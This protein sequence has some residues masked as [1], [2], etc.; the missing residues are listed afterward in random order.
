MDL[1]RVVRELSAKATG[2]TADSR[3]VRQGYV[4]VCLSDAAKQFVPDAI[5]AGAGF[6][7]IGDTDG[8]DNAGSSQFIVC[9]AR[10]DLYH[11]L[12][13]RFYQG[14]QPRFVAAVTG[15]NGKTSVAD[16]CRQIWSLTGQKGASIGTLGKIVGNGVPT[17]LCHRASLT[18]PDPAALH[19]TLRELHD[20]RVEYLCMEA[21]SHGIAQKR[22][23]SVVIQA[24][25]FTNFSQDHLGYHGS[26]EVYWATKRKLFSEVL[27]HEGCAVLNADSGKYAELKRLAKYRKVITYGINKGDV[28][29][30][31]LES[32]KFGHN[33]AVKIQSRIVY[34]GPFHVLGKFQISNLLCALALVVAS[35]S[36]HDNI[37][38]NRLVTPK[39]RMERV[40][41][42]AIVDY[43]HTPEAL[44]QA[45]TSLRWHGF[46]KKI[47]LVFG[48]GGERD[49]EK[50]KTMAMIADKYAH[51]VI[52]TD[53][54]PR[55][56]DPAAIRGEIL[57][58]CKRAIEVPDRREAIHHAISLAVRGDYMLLIVGKGHE[59]TQQIGG[60]AVEFNDA[61]V[62]KS[63]LDTVQ[64]A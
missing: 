35:A 7:V 43:A 31:H 52:I 64:Y 33:I 2:V 44:R 12:A 22:V 62:A 53:D 17:T 11:R 32:N 47:A 58:H 21:S 41:D 57:S 61:S 34:E 30:T 48:C 23:Y 36:G 25:A 46:S 42:L 26:T 63:F 4:F 16:F 15:T 10:R 51:A 50:R 24:A 14:K 38:I 20:S 28:R 59:T 37:P 27:S 6:I 13:S 40:G 54:N 9:E 56:E 60:R 8:V 18:T 19:R 55:S 29:L 1:D 39:G 3:D 49:K 45:L 5:K